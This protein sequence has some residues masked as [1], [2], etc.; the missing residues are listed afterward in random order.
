MQK[1]YRYSN[2]QEG[3]VLITVGVAHLKVKFDSSKKHPCMG[4]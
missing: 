1:N 4:G 2:K 3:M